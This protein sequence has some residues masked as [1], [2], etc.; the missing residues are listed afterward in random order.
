MNEINLDFMFIKTILYCFSFIGN[1][2]Y[3]IIHFFSLCQIKCRKN[4]SQNLGLG[5]NFMFFLNISHL[6]YSNTEILLYIYFYNHKIID[7]KNFSSHIVGQIC[8]FSRNYFELSCACWIS[9]FINP[10][11]ILL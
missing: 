5:S 9:N 4:S 3:I 11:K 7:I 10:Q 1:F 8:A 6:C 2:S